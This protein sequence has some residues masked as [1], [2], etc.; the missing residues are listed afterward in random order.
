MTWEAFTHKQASTNQP[1]HEPDIQ[2]NLLCL[3]LCPIG[4]EEQ[5]VGDDGD[6]G[7]W[8]Q[9]E[10]RQAS[11]FPSAAHFVFAFCFSLSLLSLSVLS[12]AACAQWLSQQI[13]A[14]LVVEMK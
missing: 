1:P 5:Q 3:Q 10:T 11:T 2:S 13:S 6:E 12:T 8:Q 14:L 9:D 4:E 7:R